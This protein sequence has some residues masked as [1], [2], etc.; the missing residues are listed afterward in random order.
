MSESWFPNVKYNGSAEHSLTISGPMMSP[1]W[2][3]MRAPSARSKST[4]A[5]VMGI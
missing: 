3:N 5:R 1:Q 4:A 2:T